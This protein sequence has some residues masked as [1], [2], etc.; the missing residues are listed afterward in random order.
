MENDNV[1]VPREPTEAMLNAARATGL[2]DM[3]AL[4]RSESDTYRLLWR[5]MLEAAQEKPA[6]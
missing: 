4:Y 5:S 2:A 1:I 6:R 3:S